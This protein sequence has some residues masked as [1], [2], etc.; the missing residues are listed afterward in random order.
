MLAACLL[1]PGAVAAGQGGVTI[2]VI[3][4]G[5]VFEQ[6]GRAVLAEAYRRI[7]TPLTFREMPAV[8]A[9]ALAAQGHSDGELQRMAGLTRHYPMLVQVRVPINWFDVVVLTRTARFTPAGWESLR[10][11]SIGFHRGILAIEQGTR[12]MRIDPAATNT[13]VLRKLMIGRTDIAVLPDIEAREMLANMNDGSISMLAPP[14]ER[15]QLYHY[16]QQR[17]RDLALQLETALK[18]MEADGTIAAIRARHLAGLP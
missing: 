4:Q 3:E 6:I 16:L 1:P 2:A 17:H 5:M 12:G 8:R 14:I 13:L 9:L 10:P 7:D 15:V 18:G 11:Y